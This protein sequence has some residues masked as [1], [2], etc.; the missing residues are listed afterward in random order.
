MERQGD[1]LSWYAKTVRRRLRTVIA[2]A[3]AAAAVSLGTSMLMPKIYSARASIYSLETPGPLATLGQLPFAA[4]G[5][6]APANPADYLAAVLESATVLDRVATRHNLRHNPRFVGKSDLSRDEVLE[7][8]RDCT[9]LR[10]EG[11][12][13]T[14]TVESRD[15]VLSAKIANEYLRQLDRSIHR[16][17]R[18]K[19]EFLETQLDKQEAMLAEAQD[20]LKVFQAEHEAAALDVQ[21]SEA[22]KTIAELRAQ[23][24]E[25]DIAIERNATALKT[26]GAVEEL[27]RLGVEKELLQRKAQDLIQALA[28]ESERFAAMPSTMTQ[29]ARLTWDVTARQAVVQLLQTSYESARISEQEEEARY[30]VLDTAVPPEKPI[31]PRVLL[32]AFVAG[33]LGLLAGMAWVLVTSVPA[34]QG[35]PE[36]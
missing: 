15:A 5:L 12:Q 18:R 7:A 2:V 30:Q 17:S 19:R 23:Q 33:V 20:A 34:P 10:A 14:I 8:L 13:V 4:V 27:L 32:N 9:R 22:V 6:A 26:T 28:K 24:I 31:R 36:G 16:F 11:N 1:I 21:A 3:L 25:N 35:R 29:L